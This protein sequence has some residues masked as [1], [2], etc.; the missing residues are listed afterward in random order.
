MRVVAILGMMKNGMLWTATDEELG[1]GGKKKHAPKLDAFNMKSE[2]Q[3]AASGSRRK[4]HI[5]QL[6]VVSISAA[7]GPGR[8]L[9]LLVSKP[10]T[11]P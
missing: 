2:E 10:R 4:A 1:A 6:P 5:V 8:D 9:E 3:A 7:P 11:S